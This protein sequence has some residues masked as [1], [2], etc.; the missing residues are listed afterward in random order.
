MTL[1]LTEAPGGLRS[2]ADG[3]PR[4]PEHSLIAAHD[5]VVALVMG[6]AGSGKSTIAQLLATRLSCAFQE[7]DDLHSP[8]NVVKMHAGTPLSDADRRPWLKK[9]AA[10]LQGWRDR[11]E[12]GVLSCSALKRAYRDSILGDRRGATLVYLKGP[13]A[14]IDQRLR[15][16]RG[17]FMPAALLES[18]FAELQE[19]QPDEHAIT[20]GVEG[21]AA[22][23]AADILREIL[24]RQVADA[25]GGPLAGAQRS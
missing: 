23:I 12:S 18:Q 19:P 25:V 20:V 16:R 9:I 11:G 7:G 17:H 22:D 21:R 10:V 13:Y 4:R 3:R 8:H 6:V 1:G 24:A 5:L 15:A 14:L 2:P